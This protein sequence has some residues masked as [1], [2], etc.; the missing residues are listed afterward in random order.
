MIHKKIVLNFKK[1]IKVDL[2][3]I[4]IIYVYIHIH[5]QYIVHDES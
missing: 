2:I 5:T 1:N 3:K 4:L